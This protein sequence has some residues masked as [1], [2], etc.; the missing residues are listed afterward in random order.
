MPVRSAPV[1]SRTFDH[2]PVCRLNTQK[3][4]LTR[5]LLHALVFVARQRFAMAS[6]SK[7]GTT[8]PEHGDLTKSSDAPPPAI[9]Q[10]SSEAFHLDNR[11]ACLNVA[12]KWFDNY[13]GHKYGS[14]LHKPNVNYASSL[15]EVSD[16][17]VEQGNVMWLLQEFGI[18]FA[19]NTLSSMHRKDSPL[20][21]STKFTYFK[22][23]KQVLRRCFP[24]HPVLKSSDD[25]WWSD[26][27]FSFQNWLSAP[28][29]LILPCPAIPPPFPFKYRD[30]TTQG[31][32]PIS[33]GSPRCSKT[34]SVTGTL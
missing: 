17:S 19:S 10:R 32:I 30:V 34:Q 2:Q 6:P 3:P 33:S 23:M 1:T 4:E 28:S 7:L 16:K 29:C 31:T 11:V 20:E 12:Q 18:L 8:S 25:S 5:S 9:P 13:L 21:P 24:D 26:L 15:A 14:D 22:A 27:L